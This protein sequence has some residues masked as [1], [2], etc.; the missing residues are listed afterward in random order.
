MR[1]KQI[2][3]NLVGNGIKFTSVGQVDVNI[4]KLEDSCW[5]IIVRDTGIGIPAEALDYVFEQFRQV[6][7]SSTRRYEGTGLGLAIVQRLVT[8]MGGSIA[9]QSEV[10]KGSTFTIHLPLIAE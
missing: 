3:I 4:M 8:L 2:L 6:D 1:L 7:N 10:E 5:T 9:V